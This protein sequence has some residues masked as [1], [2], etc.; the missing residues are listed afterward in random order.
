[1]K[2]EKEF[3]TILDSTTRDNLIEALKKPGTQE[4]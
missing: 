2:S 4:S 3:E 1:M